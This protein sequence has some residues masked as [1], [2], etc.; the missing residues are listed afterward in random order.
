MRSPDLSERGKFFFFFFLYTHSSRGEYTFRADSAENRS[1]LDWL[2][3]VTTDSVVNRPSQ[4]RFLAESVSFELSRPTCDSDSS[5]SGPRRIRL[6]RL[7]SDSA[8]SLNHDFLLL[9]FS[10][11]R[12][13][14][15][16]QSLTMRSSNFSSLRLCFKYFLKSLHT[17]G[18]FSTI[19]AT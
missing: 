7:V 2:G 1:R 19:V 5:R 8:E 6:G 17:S 10:D 12:L 11:F 16:I 9:L 3:R 14:S 13:S 4:L 18:S 15:S